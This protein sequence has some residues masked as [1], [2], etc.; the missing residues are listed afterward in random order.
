M[1]QRAEDDR[2]IKNIKVEQN[3]RR[4]L[5]RK[6]DVDNAKAYYFM[7]GFMG[8]LLLTVGILSYILS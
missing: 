7:V 6:E 1:M 2:R 5:R 3:N 4:K 8:C